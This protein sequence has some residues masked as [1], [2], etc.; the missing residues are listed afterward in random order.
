[1]IQTAIGQTELLINKKFQQFRGLID[2]C[3]SGEGEKPVT[4]MDL[5]GFWD[6]VLIQVIYRDKYCN[7]FYLKY[8]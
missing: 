8:F 3:I 7:I 5:H 1:M 6:M 4:C 2:V